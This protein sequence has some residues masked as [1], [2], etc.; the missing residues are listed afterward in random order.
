MKNIPTINQE[1]LGKLESYARDLGFKIRGRNINEEEGKEA[2][3]TLHLAPKGFGKSMQESPKPPERGEPFIFQPQ[4]ATEF[5]F[6]AE[7]GQPEAGE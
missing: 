7:T 4:A 3:L 6:G 1:A 2:R 5:V